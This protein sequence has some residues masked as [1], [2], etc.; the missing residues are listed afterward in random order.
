ME[1]EQINNKPA[2]FYCGCK[3]VLVVHLCVDCNEAV[4]QTLDAGIL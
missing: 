2:C 1:S 3:K 4:S